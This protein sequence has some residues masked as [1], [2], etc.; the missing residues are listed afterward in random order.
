MNPV[1]YIRRTVFKLSQEAF[2]ALFGTTQ[3]TVSRW[4]KA[5]LIPS[6]VQPKVR[7][8]AQDLGI[9]WNDSWFF[10]VPEGGPAPDCPQ[11]VPAPATS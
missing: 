8:A 2:G 11:D 1:T 10:A 7:K 6:D 9:N 5:G 4:E 3:A